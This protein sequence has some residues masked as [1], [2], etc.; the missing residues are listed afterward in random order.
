[1]KKTKKYTIKILYKK[2]IL[3]IILTKTKSYILIMIKEKNV[4]NIKT[5]EKDGE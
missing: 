3:K 2:N 5:N 4:E 1:V